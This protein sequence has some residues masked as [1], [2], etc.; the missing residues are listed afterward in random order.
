[1]PVKFD[2]ICEAFEFVNFG[3]LGENQAFLD[4]ETGAIYYQSD[5]MDEEEELPEDLDTSDRYISIPDQRDLD[6]GRRLVDRFVR[7]YLPDEI[8]KVRTIFSRSGAYARFKDLLEYRD[9]LEQWY[10]FESE[11]KNRELREWCEMNSI[12]LEEDGV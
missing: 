2:E 6:L 4:L 8:G 10:A 12:D 5:Y 1:M 3:G 11:A 9:L 7:Q